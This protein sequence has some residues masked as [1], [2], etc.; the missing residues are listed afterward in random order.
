MAFKTDKKRS[1][2]GID[3]RAFEDL[4]A[5]DPDKARLVLV[6]GDENYLAEQVISCMEDY[7]V[8][9]GARDMDMNVIDT[10]FS[11]KFDMERLIDSAMCVPWMSK[12]RLVVVKGADITSYQA[13]DRDLEF[14]K[15]LPSSCAILFWD[16]DAKFKATT[17]VYKAIAASGTVVAT[18]IGDENEVAEWIKSKVSSDGYRIDD[19]CAV[20]IAGRCQNSLM[21]VS[22]ELEKLYLYCEA[23]NTRVLSY[24]MI[25]DC[26]PPDLTAV[27]FDIMD[28]C[29]TG[30]ADKALSTLSRLL[31]AGEP[32]ARLRTT[33]VGYLRKL[34]IAKDLGSQD[35][36]CAETGMHPYPAG[37][38][39][40]QVR[41]FPMERLIKLYIDGAHYDSEFKHGNIDERVALELLI[42][43][44]CGAR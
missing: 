4:M 6:H 28:S 26:C 14:L 31:S 24:E 8:A 19:R 15:E 25:E 27:V 37:K 7:W 21:T 29:G 41:N 38:M 36:L 20:S 30:S 9:P 12:A 32:V 23:K 10:R 34:I 22:H 2:A 35:A 16:Q 17:S 39:I 18:P 11:E 42:I 13:T 5:K 33:V 1:K 43:A 44:A 40:R 3:I